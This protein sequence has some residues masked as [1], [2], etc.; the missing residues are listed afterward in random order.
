M[1]AGLLYEEIICA[2]EEGTQEMQTAG[3]AVLVSLSN[4]DLNI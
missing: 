4:P 1:S 3:M 2:H